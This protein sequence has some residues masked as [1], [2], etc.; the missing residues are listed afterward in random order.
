MAGNMHTESFPS[1][2]M[3][4]RPALQVLV[5]LRRDDQ[6]VVTHMSAA[7]EWPKRCRHPLDFHYVPSTMGGA[8]PLAL[9]LALAQP[10]RK[11]LALSG[12]G[13]LSMHLGSLISVVASGAPNISVVLLDNGVYE[14]TGGQKTASRLANTDF[15]G[16][17]RAAGFPNVAQFWNLQDWRR[18]A[19][20]V[21]QASGPCFVWLQVQTVTDEYHLDPPCLM[22]EQLARFRAALSRGAAT[23]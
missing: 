19:G 7:R 20:G 16:L 6:I 14:V 18:R 13:S 11:V 2:R 10:H 4:V 3:P 5:E 1:D 8:V 22:S 17:A 15:A 21:L 12:D 23:E 9:G